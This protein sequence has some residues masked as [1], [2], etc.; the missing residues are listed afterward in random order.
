M[1]RRADRAAGARGQ[2]LATHHHPQQIQSDRVPSRW[3][4][5]P[6]LLLPS[7]KAAGSTNESAAPR[8]NR[9]DTKHVPQTGAQ[10]DSALAV[11]GPQPGAGEVA[12]AGAL[13]QRASGHA[14]VGAAQRMAAVKATAQGQRLVMASPGR[15]A[16]AQPA[17]DSPRVGGTG[18]GLAKSGAVAQM[19]PALKLLLAAAVCAAAKALVAHGGSPMMIASTR[20]V[21]GRPPSALTN[22]GA[23]LPSHMLTSG[24]VAGRSLAG[25]TGSVSG[26]PPFGL[27]CTPADR[28][29]SA[30]GRVP[31]GL[32]GGA[33]GRPPAG[34]TGSVARPQPLADHA[35]FPPALP[36]VPPAA[37]TAAPP[38]V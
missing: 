18:K 30:T 17:P 16:P 7:T 4:G 32:I 23:R 3:H 27:T 2:R 5:C 26:R 20:D 11:P 37:S 38:L 36:L 28:T 31:G 1:L 15:S 24:S 8:A 13:Q 25:L 21:T 34:L 12:S 29:G 10:R 33:A 9:V 6:P 35:V 19:S 14:G 22:S